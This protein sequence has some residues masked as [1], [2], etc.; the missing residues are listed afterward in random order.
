MIIAIDGPA[1]SGK[2][3]LARRLAATLGLPHLDTGA[4]YR[5]T[6]LQVL[7]RGGDPASAETAAQ[8]ARSLDPVSIPS[9]TD[10]PELRLDTVAQAASQVAALPEVRAALLQVQR[11]FAH[12]PG[13]AVLDG[14]DIGTVVCP[15]ADAKLFV[16]ADRG[17]RAER[18][19]RELK[20]SDTS[21]TY[22]AVLADMERRD[23]RDSGRT[24]APLTPATD[25]FVLNTD[26]LDADQAF[27]AA[28]AFIQGRSGSQG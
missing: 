9:L 19:F 5:L 25:A 26:E 3:T 15:G 24:I 13:G 4:L 8:A 7:R 18:R 16:T 10:D 6:A 20:A 12:Q 17:I 14:R 21:V 23:A 11:D 27:A 28:L 2:G 1:A 22:A